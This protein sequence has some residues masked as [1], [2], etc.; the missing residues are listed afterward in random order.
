MAQDKR[1]DGEDGKPLVEDGR[2]AWKASTDDS[3]EIG[4]ELRS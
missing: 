4:I 1:D 2:I 3:P